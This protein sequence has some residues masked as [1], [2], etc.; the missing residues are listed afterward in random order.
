[1]TAK[2]TRPHSYRVYDKRLVPWYRTGTGCAWSLGAASQPNPALHLRREC[3]SRPSGLLKFEFGHNT[4]IN[5]HGVSLEIYYSAAT[6][7]APPSI[8]PPTTAATANGF[9]VVKPTSRHLCAAAVHH[10]W[11]RRHRQR[12]RCHH[13]RCNRL[14]PPPLL[15]PQ[16]KTYAPLPFLCPLLAPQLRETLARHPG[17]CC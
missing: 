15:P 3:D 4:R 11:C 13:R 10:L 16:P 9:L 12:N 14:V 8:P 2:T 7:P 17:S 6:P 1:V 5:F